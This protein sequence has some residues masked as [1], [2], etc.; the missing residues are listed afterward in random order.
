MLTSHMLNRA[1]PPDPRERDWQELMAA[2]AERAYTTERTRCRAA[3]LRPRPESGRTLL[4]R[5]GDHRTERA[6]QGRTPPPTQ[7]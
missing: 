5:M 3:P 4:E 7:A 6:A 1:P 2:W